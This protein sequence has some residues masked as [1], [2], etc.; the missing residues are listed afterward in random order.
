MTSVGEDVKNGNTCPLFMV[1]YS[2]STATEN[3][4]AILKK[5]KIELLCDLAGPLWV[6]TPVKIRTLETSIH[7]CSIIHNSQNEETT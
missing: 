4:M 7:P 5:S 1:L 6:Y 3:G 2:T